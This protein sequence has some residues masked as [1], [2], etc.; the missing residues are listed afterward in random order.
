ME[1][2]LPE[3]HIS[4]N[5]GKLLYLLAKL[6]GAQRVL[7]IGLLGGYSTMWLARAIGPRGKIITLE[8]DERC[9]TVARKNLQRAKLLS[10]VDIRH[11]DARATLKQMVRNR[12][13]PLD[14]VFIDADKPSYPVYL[15]CA[16]KLTRPGGLILADNVIRDGKV[17]QKHKGDELVEGIK[18]FNKKLAAN[19]KLE[20]ILI[21][22]MRKK[23]DGLGIARV[24]D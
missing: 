6:S 15:D 14:L 9:V 21:P 10:R 16:L 7:E 22:I 23:I 4:P 1:A 13:R 20:A 8:I 19:R 2:G 12:E 17:A 18:K 3:I 24:K 5:E 11:G